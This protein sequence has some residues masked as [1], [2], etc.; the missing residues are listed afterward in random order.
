MLVRDWRKLAR[1]ALIQGA[2]HR[3]IAE[4]IGWKS[5]TYVGRIL[6]GEIRTMDP[7]SAVR[8]CHYFGVAVDD[9][10]MTKSSRNP[11]RSVNE[12]VAS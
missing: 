3:Q 8:L 12:R 9:F 7:A 2:T 6:R 1:L 11:G 5:H 4:A 10:F